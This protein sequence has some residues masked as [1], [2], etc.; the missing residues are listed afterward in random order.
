MEYFSNSPVCFPYDKW[1]VRSNHSSP[2]P[3][4]EPDAWTTHLSRCW[5]CTPTTYAQWWHIQWPRAT[6]T[7]A[8]HKQWSTGVL[9]VRKLYD[10][11]HFLVLHWISN[12]SWLLNSSHPWQNGHLIFRW[13]FVNEKFCILIKILL[14]FVP[15]GPID[16]DPALV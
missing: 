3:R 7:V 15:K 11:F 5:K 9:S 6:I 4:L 2:A 16:N 12:I 1:D 10:V 8:V 14:K 13:I